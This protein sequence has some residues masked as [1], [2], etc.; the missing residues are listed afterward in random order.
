[1]DKTCRSA[2]FKALLTAQFMGAVTDSLLKVV[3]SLY[4]IQILL[5]SETATRAVSI[6]GVLYVLPYVLCSPFAGYLADRFYKRHVIIAM[7]AVKV[8]FAA[9]AAWALWSG[10]L[11][12]LCGTLFLFMV[13]SALFSPSKLGILPEM[14]KEDELSKGNGYIQL[15]SFVGIILGTATGGVLFKIV[16]AH[17]YQIGLLMGIL[18]FI[19]FGASFFIHSDRPAPAA[20]QGFFS[21]TWRAFRG[22]RKDQGLFLTMAALAFFNFLGAVF[23]MNILIYGAHV[24]VVDQIHISILLVA[25]SLGIALG[26]IL[27]GGAS[28]G[29]VE[30]GLVPLGAMGITMMSFFLGFGGNFYGALG[31]LFILGVCAGFYTVPLNA[32][33]QQYSPKE[34][35]GQYLSVLNM[36]SSCGSLLAGGFLWF[37]GGRLGIGADKIFWIV[38]A[39][40]FIATIY[41]VV[42]LPVFLVRLINW[43]IAHAVYKIRVINSSQVPEEGGALLISNHISY[44]DAILILAALKRPVR[45]IMYR[46]I[47]ELPFVNFFGRVLKVIPIDR[48]GGPKAIAGALAEARKAIENG[49][50]VCIFPEGVLTRTGNMLPFSKGFEHIMKGLNAPIIPLYLDNIWGSVYTFANGKYFWKIPRLAQSP[51]SVVFG[52]PMTG[53]SKVH[54][55]RLAVQELGAEANILRGAWRKKLHLAFI[56]EVKRHPFKLCMADSMGARF[57]YPKVFAAAVMLSKVLLPATRI[58]RETNEMVGVL[59]PSSSMAAISNIAV[60]FAGKVPVNLNF[61]LSAEAFDSCIKQCRMRMIITSRAFLEKAGIAARPEMVFLEDVRP[62]ISAI[63]AGLYFWAAFL[64]PKWVLTAMVVR[65]DKTNIDDVATV[66]FSS[67]STGE[68]KGILLTHANIFSNIEGLYQ[69]FNIRKNDVIVSALPFFHSL[70][71]TATLCFPAGTALGVVYHTNPLDAGTIGKLVEKY[72]GTILMGT[73]TF[74]SAYVKKCSKEQFSSVRLAVVGAEKLKE[75]LAKAFQEKF[76]VIPF[77]GYGATELSPIVTVGFPDYVNDETVEHQVGNKFGKV[78]HPIPGVAVK[79]VDPDTFE[80]KGP[81]EDGLLLVKGANVMRG[82]LNN[83]AKTAEVMKDGWYITGDIATI[84]EDGFIKIT[85]RLSR[86]SKIGGEMVPHVKVEENIMEALGVVDPVVVVTSV[87]DEKKGER[88]VVLYTV[89]MDVDAVCESLTRKGIPNL[90]IPKKDSFYRVEVIPVLGTGKTDLKGVKALAQKMAE[91]RPGE[92]GA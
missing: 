92:P 51:V 27:A 35:R 42:T 64:F 65:G 14:L 6:I 77:E 71:F 12:F 58:P 29:K 10:D 83:P 2:S 20:H 34:E 50:L 16:N 32:F 75:P 66:I 45:F 7:G 67:G 37:Y 91:A 61:T 85:D 39:L 80:M 25:V 72:K 4:A 79:I 57:T 21:G 8:V 22:I 60:S 63:K 18:A 43:L 49:E 11:W 53:A 55:V 23:Q 84:D 89:E 17:L 3:V 36:V 19:S 40:S 62:K 68:P 59:L 46:R 52:K 87:P 74:M 70:G 82:Y 41:I 78:G 33:F 13:D 48:E 9:L 47:Y 86:F 88:L 5:S 90:W 28:D 44:V 1:M 76:G 31:M 24:L 26:S 56:D 38:A 30:L 81:N 15:W 73:P 69:I 54:E